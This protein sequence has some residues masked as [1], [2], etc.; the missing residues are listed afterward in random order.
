[1]GAG[2]YGC[3]GVWVLGCMGAG[4]YGCWGVWVLWCVGA[5]VYGCWGVWFMGAGSGGVGPVGGG[6]GG[7]GGKLQLGR[8]NNDPSLPYSYITC[9]IMKKFS[10]MNKEEI[11][12]IYL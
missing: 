10:L 11:L 5:G 7:G 1:M 3:W 2:V 6:G 12:V 4:V 9:F 8:Y